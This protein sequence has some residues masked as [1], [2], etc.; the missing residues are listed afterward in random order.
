MLLPLLALFPT[1]LSCNQI[2]I[3]F[4]V[5]FQYKKSLSYFLP[6]VGDA[7]NCC[8]MSS[9]AKDLMIKEGGISHSTFYTLRAI[10]YDCNC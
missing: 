6:T 4:T 10:S 9:D 2:K 8:L 5:K 1:A 7:L 3:K